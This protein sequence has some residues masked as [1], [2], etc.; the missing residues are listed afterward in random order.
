M[1][2]GH[3]TFSLRIKEVGEHPDLQPGFYWTL[4]DGPEEGCFWV[5]PEPTPDAAKEKAVQSI[6]SG[7]AAAARQLLEGN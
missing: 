1:S 3:T 2:D 6:A 4:D 7:Y 5:G